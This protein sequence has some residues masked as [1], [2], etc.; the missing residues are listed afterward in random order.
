ME[1]LIARVQALP[2]SDIELSL[3]YFFRTLHLMS[4]QLKRAQANY[5]EISLEQRRDFLG[6]PSTYHLC[7]TIIMENTAYDESAAADPWYPRHIAVIVQYEARMNAEKIMKFMKDYQ[8]SQS[9]KKLSRKCFHFRLA[10]E[11]VAR[12]LTGYGYN[13]IT[14]FLMKTKVPVLLS[15]SVLE[16]TPQYFWMGGGEVDLKLGMS[17]EE[18]ISVVQPLVADTNF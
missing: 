11:G 15:K 12:E 6:A 16:L 14:P 7:K 17:V 3:R 18:F 5:Y 4:V 10:D 13:A 2:I 1:G 9:P 8:N